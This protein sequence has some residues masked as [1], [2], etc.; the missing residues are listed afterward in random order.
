EN[1]YWNTNSAFECFKNMIFCLE[2]YTKQGLYIG[3]CNDYNPTISLFN[4]IK[5]FNQTGFDDY[6]NINSLISTIKG[7]I[8]PELMK[9]IQSENENY[10]GNIKNKDII[11]AK[12]FEKE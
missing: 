4:V 2:S 12:N 1:N 9:K 6:E 3:K 10:L 5:K 11:I 7:K 8:P